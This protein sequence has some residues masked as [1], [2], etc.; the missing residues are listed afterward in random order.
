MREPEISIVVI[1]KIL[2]DSILLHFKDIFPHVQCSVSNRLIFG[3]SKVKSEGSNKM[4]TA[5]INH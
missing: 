2:F 3:V 1:F 4:V 5:M